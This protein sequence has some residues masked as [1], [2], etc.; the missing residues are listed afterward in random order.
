MRAPPQQLYYQSSE[1]SSHETKCQTKNRNLHSDYAVNQ[2]EPKKL[3][4][5]INCS[6]A[7]FKGN[8]RNIALLTA[9][10]PPQLKN[11]QAQ[12]GSWREVKCY[13]IIIRHYSLFSRCFY[14][15]NLAS[16]SAEKFIRLRLRISF[17]S[18]LHETLW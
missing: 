16:F 1:C 18:F 17:S 2:R 14:L 6:A 11:T 7:P 4:S 10:P 5:I 12:A 13:F 15:Q 9:N 3:V 8:F